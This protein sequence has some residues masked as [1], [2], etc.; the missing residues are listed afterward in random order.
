MRLLISAFIPQIPRGK[1]FSKYSWG[2]TVNLWNLYNSLLQGFQNGKKKKH[3]EKTI[4]EPIV[5]LNHYLINDHSSLNSSVI[6]I[7]V[8]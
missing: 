2:Y 1:K 8:K 6:S 4:A 5:M 7:L 3:R